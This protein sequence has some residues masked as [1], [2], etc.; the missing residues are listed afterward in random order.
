MSA[1]DDIYEG[2]ATIGH[3]VATITLIVCCIIG[4]VM[5]AV[6]LYMM[7]RR[8]KK[9][10]PTVP[11]DPTPDMAHAQTAVTAP[12]ASK[13]M[14]INNE[15]GLRT[16]GLILLLVGLVIMIC[17]IVNYILTVKFKLFAA[18]GGVQSVF[19]I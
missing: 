13:N 12:P 10:V 15:K 17:A 14:M 2:A 18:A 11:T 7:L 16:I 1:Y 4:P 6:G 5:I 19:D 9:T 3:I 8:H